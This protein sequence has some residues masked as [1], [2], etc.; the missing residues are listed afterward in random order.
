MATE[1][2]K[3]SKA[4]KRRKG[5]KK[6]KIDSDPMLCSSL[7]LSVPSLHHLRD[8]SRSSPKRTLGDL[9]NSNPE[10]AR[11]ADEKLSAKKRQKV[12]DDFEPAEKVCLIATETSTMDSEYLARQMKENGWKVTIVHDGNNVLTLLKQRNWGDSAATF[13]I[14]ATPA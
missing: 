4:S 14:R 3:P 5:L 7:G 2:A 8:R 6:Q 13:F 12:A 11:L 10:L 1:L 9:R